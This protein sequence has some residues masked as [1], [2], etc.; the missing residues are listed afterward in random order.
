MLNALYP[1]IIGLAPLHGLH[2]LLLG[3][4]RFWLTAII[5]APAA[6]L[7]LDF[8]VLVFQRQFAPKGSQILQEYEKRLGTAAA[9]APSHGAATADLE[10]GPPQVHATVKPAGRATAPAAAAAATGSNI[11]LLRSNV[12]RSSDQPQSV[13][14]DDRFTLVAEAAP[15]SDQFDVWTAGKCTPCIKSDVSM[16]YVIYHSILVYMYVHPTA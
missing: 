11:N 10:L 13:T 8:T 9:A 3:S 1:R 5:G 12:I 15:M 6:A 4:G 7:L 16:T 2:K 14:A